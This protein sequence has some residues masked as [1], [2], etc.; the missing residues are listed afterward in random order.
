MSVQGQE[1]RWTSS[2]IGVR[3]A[4]DSRHDTR[5]ID[6]RLRTGFRTNAAL[7]QQVLSWVNADRANNSIY[8]S[9]EYACANGGPGNDLFADFNVLA[10]L[11]AAIDI[12][13]AAEA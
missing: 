8:R 2:W 1:Q 11:T 12:L 6:F 13:Q 7:R 10:T 9:A 4:P 5:S 3:F